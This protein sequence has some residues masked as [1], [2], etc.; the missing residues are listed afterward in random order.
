MTASITTRFGIYRWSSDSDAFTRTQA[1]DSHRNLELH[2]A[3]MLS[4]T[5]VPSVGL[6]SYAKTLFLNRANNRI[7]Y[8][9]TE[10]ASGEWIYIET[11]VILSIIAEAKG[12]LIVASAPN[13]WT[14]LPVGTVNQILTVL[15]NSADVGWSTIL[16][17]K[18]DLL[19]LEGTTAIRIGVGADNQLLH[20]SSSSIGGLQW[21]LAQT[22]SI[23][24]SA[25][26]TVKINNLAVTTQKIVD[27]SV[28]T[29][30]IANESISESK[31]S[32]SAV[33][34]SKI[35]DLAVTTDKIAALSITESKLALSSVTTPKIMD[36]A[37][38][39]DKVLDLA[40]LES[41]IADSA[42][43]EEKIFNN[44]ITSV[45]IAAGA[46]IET[47]IADNAV[48]EL[49]IAEQNVTTPKI[50]AGAIITPKI[51]DSA[52]TG[53]KI[54]SGS[55][56]T[57]QINNLAATTIKLGDGQVTSN[58]FAASAVIDSKIADSNVTTIK[59]SD[60]SVSSGKFSSG[61]VTNAKIR[62][63]P[64]TTVFGNNNNIEANPS[65]IVAANDN[66]VLLRSG[67]ILTFSQVITPGFANSSVTSSGLLDGTLI[68]EDFNSAANINLTKLGTG[69][70]PTGIKTD[71]INYI[72]RSITQSKLNA[73]ANSEGVGAWVNYT[74]SLFYTKHSPLGGGSFLGTDAQ[75][76]WPGQQVPTSRYA[77]LYS[78]YCKIN[79]LCLVSV[80]VKA[81]AY[82]CS[83]G[84]ISFSLPF[85]SSTPNHKIVG[86]S[87]VVNVDG[88]PQGH[89][90]AAIFSN[91][92]V[93]IPKLQIRI[94]NVSYGGGAQQLLP[95]GSGSSIVV[96]SNFPVNE[97]YSITNTF[98]PE[99]RFHHT[100]IETNDI[101]SFNIS[102][103]TTA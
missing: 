81:T 3:K 95:S 68:N 35:A 15:N 2:L 101:L 6:S 54:V 14:I 43:T 49:K 79:N 29:A 87:T 93:F 45:K 78:K 51:L 89:T 7:Y 63:F 16:T 83:A 69:P 28:T 31:V 59:I 82:I 24:D 56:G 62:Q 9:T 72:D 11:D 77:V 52:V 92:V 10:D 58:K 19:T 61:S 46:V 4:G 80:T 26:T 53:S 71:N 75:V 100:Y 102:Y 57:P 48:T 67:N 97:W 76:P 40:V 99:A 23:A 27:S 55:I 34:T 98:P 88:L 94:I 37:V 84:S 30:K 22:Q 1:D 33:D 47:V 17:N 85:P 74:P 21:T 39:T 18:G 36:G 42:V 12:D 50:A 90:L 70:L 96:G 32:N 20:S 103:E 44:S 60:Q 64:S 91:R 5:A 8:Y 38:T 25:V 41:K 66:T 86:T 73:T 13:T 65:N